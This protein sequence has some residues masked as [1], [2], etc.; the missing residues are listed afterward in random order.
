MTYPDPQWLVDLRAQAEAAMAAA[1]RSLTGAA[2]LA[3]GL[4]AQARICI[5]QVGCRRCYG[6][7]SAPTRAAYAASL[8]Q[9]PCT[10]PERCTREDCQAPGLLADLDDPPRPCPRGVIGCD[11][12]TCTWVCECGCQNSHEVFCYL[13]GAGNP[14]YE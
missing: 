8:G 12:K 1:E 10:C 2:A 7:M 5:A 4:A 6:D 13:C 14:A 11:G 3:E 9:G